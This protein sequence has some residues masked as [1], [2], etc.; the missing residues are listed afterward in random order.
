MDNTTPDPGIMGSVPSNFG[1]A[2][3]NDR[4]KLAAEELVR[5][6]HNHSAK[7]AAQKKLIAEVEQRLELEKSHLNVLIAQEKQIG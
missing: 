2:G 5:I 4:D 3:A 6:R 7:I 1:W